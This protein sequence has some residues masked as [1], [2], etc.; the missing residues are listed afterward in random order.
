MTNI[1]PNV[2]AYVHVVH[3]IR[4]RAATLIRFLLFF[5]LFVVENIDLT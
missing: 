5:M 3:N 4:R 2:V 1:H